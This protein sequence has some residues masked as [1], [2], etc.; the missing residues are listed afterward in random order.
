MSRP[1]VSSVQAS[2]KMVLRHPHMNQTD[3]LPLGE[4]ERDLVDHRHYKDAEDATAGRS[5][6][7]HIL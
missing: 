1:F 6:G 5:L 7:L 3:G 2:L 4:Q